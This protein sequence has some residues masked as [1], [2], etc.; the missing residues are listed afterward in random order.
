MKT[1]L[2]VF[3][4]RKLE[5][6][7]EISKLKRYSYNTE[8]DLKEG[9]LISSKSYDSYLQV[10]KILPRDFMYYNSATGEMSNEFN[11][12][13]QRKIKTLVINQENDDNIIHGRIL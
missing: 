2:V 11:S 10:V 8:A 7:S 6:D 1:V 12:S 13:D 3:T 5:L 4:K 9:D